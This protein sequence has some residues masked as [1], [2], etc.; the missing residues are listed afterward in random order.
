MAC[1]VGIIESEDV[2]INSFRRHT[3]GANHAG[4]FYGLIGLVVSLGGLRHTALVGIEPSQVFVFGST[5]IFQ[6]LEVLE[7]AGCIRTQALLVLFKLGSVSGFIIAD[8]LHLINSSLTMESILLGFPLV[9]GH[10]AGHLEALTRHSV[11]GI[12]FT[13][14]VHVLKVGAG[15]APA[16]RMKRWSGEPHLV[17]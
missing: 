16:P 3:N 2:R 15:A 14:A 13:R 4:G 17:L 11:T 9:I 5:V 6:G 1:G 12:A 8:F 10:V 7:I